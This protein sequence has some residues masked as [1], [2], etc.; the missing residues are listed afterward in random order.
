MLGHYQNI[1]FPN[2]FTANSSG[3]QEL[4]TNITDNQTANVIAVV[5][6]T[7]AAKTMPLS[8]PV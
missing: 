4:K 7:D 6:F 2:G 8:N 3:I 1:S 5:Q